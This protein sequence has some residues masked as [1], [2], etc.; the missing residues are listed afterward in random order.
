LPRPS[1]RHF[2][3][4]EARV[5][6]LAITRI[7]QGLVAKGEQLAQHLCD[8]YQPQILVIEQ[9][10]SRGSRRS[11]H[12]PALTE[13]IKAL[14]RARR[15]TVVEYTTGEMRQAMA[16][17]ELGVTTATLC[18]EIAALYPELAPY[19]PKLHRGIGDTEPYYTLLFKAVAL[20]LTW[21]ERQRRPRSAR[22]ASARSTPADQE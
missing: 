11:R 2:P 6:N 3:L 16:T 18:Q 4:V 21:W 14:A 22:S 12:L 8:T 17:D 15:V 5:R 20:G 7:P 19:L 1:S 13:A 10:A 9:P